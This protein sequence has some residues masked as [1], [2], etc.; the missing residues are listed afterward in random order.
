MEFNTLSS[1]EKKSAKRRTMKEKEARVQTVF[2]LVHE[3]DYDD[4]DDI[5]KNCLFLTLYIEIPTI[6]LVDV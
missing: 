1:I 5:P 4:Y 3:S 6:N 2:F